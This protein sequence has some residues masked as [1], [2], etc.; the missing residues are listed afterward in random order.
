MKQAASLE[1]PSHQQN[2]TGFVRMAVFATSAGL[3]VMLASLASL[4][5]DEQGLRFIWSGWVAAAF[6]TGAGLGL[7][8]WRTA[9][10]LGRLAGVDPVAAKRRRQTFT[11]VSALMVFAAVFAFLY[12]MKFVRP[13][14]R[15][16]VRA[17][18]TMVP[19]VVI[20]CLT[21]WYLTKRFLDA[22]TASAE[23]A[24]KDPTPEG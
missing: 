6:L 21:G 10:R 8:Y 22:D 14:K 20:P 5:S 17:G 23:A 3:G 24:E 18:L 12:P 4:E 7:F 2:E 9:L 16:D 19:F 13:E 15:D 11:L 1:P